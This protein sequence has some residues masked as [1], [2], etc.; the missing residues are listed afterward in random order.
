M[1][2]GVLI[3]TR[4][5]CI[6]LAPVVHALEARGAA[7]EVYVTGQHREL[8][9]PLFEDLSLTPTLNL[10]LMRPDQ[11]LSGLSARILEAMEPLLRDRQPGYMV[12]QGDTTTVAM[13]AL[14]CFYAG[15]PVAHVE[16]GLRTGVR[17]NPFPEEMNRRMAAVL[18]DWHFAPTPEARDNLLREGVA[19]DRI[20]V[21]GNTVI[22]ALFHV[23]EQLAPK[24][25]P[26]PILV[27]VYA[28]GRD[29]V[30]I[31]GHRRENFGPDFASM[32]RGIARL[33]LEFPNVA[34]VY[35]VHPNPHV[36][37]A[38]DEHLRGLD[39]V[40][41]T[42][43]QPY[44][45]F[46]QLLSKTKLI[47]TDSGGV[48]EEGAALGIPMLVTRHTCERM[49]AVRAGVSKLVGPSEEAIFAHGRELLSDPAVYAAQAR[50]TNVFGD[51]HAADRIA[52]V[53]LREGAGT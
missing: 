45:R 46:I 16:A 29:I 4:P 47:I 44:V 10:E 25:Q 11:S 39:N 49:E 37:A 24:V 27:P 43:P 12:A 48:Q 2:I 32:C 51:G 21:I 20:H 31:T 19:A 17:R 26:D 8:L 35:P 5:E 33:A 42:D 38:V 53:L 3:G 52:E 18:A 36:R 7:V 34:F 15:V 28:S 50:P 6:K 40:L 23:R 22:D 14:A 9:D 1:T 13:G 30:L 41:L